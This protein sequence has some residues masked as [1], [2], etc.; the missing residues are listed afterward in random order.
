MRDLAD[1]ALER[2]LREALAEHVGTLPLD[3]TV[4]ALDHRRKTKSVDRRFGRG[5]GMTLLA[6]AAAVGLAGGA[7]VVGSGVLRQQAIVRPPVTAPSRG[8][9]AIASAGMS[10]P[11][12][13]L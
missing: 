2:R 3:L 5:R 11:S 9:L 7:L 4:D 6:A 8:P 12:P 13:S 1:A 10:S